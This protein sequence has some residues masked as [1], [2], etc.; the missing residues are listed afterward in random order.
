MKQRRTYLK[1]QAKKVK[2][3]LEQHLRMK[4]RN[5]LG[6]SHDIKAFWAQKKES[7][8]ERSEWAKLIH[9]QLMCFKININ[10]II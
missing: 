4:E 7:D 1:K 6:V 3:R 2:L 5:L 9:W 10:D 8:R